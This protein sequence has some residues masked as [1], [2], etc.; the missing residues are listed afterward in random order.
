P[1][2][3]GSATLQITESTA[4]EL[5]ADSPFGDDR[6]VIH[7]VAG[8]APIYRVLRTEPE[9]YTPGQ[10]LTFH[11]EI[12]PAPLTLTGAQR[13]SANGISAHTIPTTPGANGRTRGQHTV[14][15]PSN[16]SGTL[17]F[18]FTAT[19]SGGTTRKSIAIP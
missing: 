18:P 11:W 7:I 1:I 16:R 19:S 5:V 2:F 13:V 8:N 4:V 3:T 9:R 15:I 14:N 6:R 17:T 12:D 10:P